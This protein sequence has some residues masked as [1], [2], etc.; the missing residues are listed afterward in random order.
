MSFILWMLVLGSILLILALA[1]AYLRLLPV[2]TSAFYLL[3]GLAIGPL[4]LGLWDDELGGVSQWLERLVEVTVLISLFIGGLRLRLP[5]RAPEWRA[6]CLL[7][8]PVLVGTILGLALFAHY[9]LGLDWGLALLLAAILSPTDPVLASLIQVSHAGDTDP[10]RFALS[11]EAG[12]NDGIAFPFVLAG[13][14]LMAYQGPAEVPLREGLE[15][16][17]RYVLWAIPAGLALGFLLGRGVGQLVIHLRARHTDT[18]VS[19]ND[20]LAL[21]LI[22]MSYVGA[23][24][25]GGWGFLS[26]FAAGLGLRQA[27][28]ATS[29]HEQ[30]PAEDTASGGERREAS[31]SQA[32]I[33]FGADEGQHRQVAAGALMVDI[34]AFGNLLERTLEVLLVT[35][36]G[37]LLYA[38]WDWRALTLALGLFVLV[39]PVMVMALLGGRLLAPSQRMLVGWFGIR[40]IGS[41]YYLCH[42]LNLGLDGKAAALAS[43][44]VISVVALSILLH[45][46]TIQPLLERYQR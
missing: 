26:T 35:I 7:A 37:A 46:L 28:V 16:F 27:E 8:G 43:D 10:M 29:G 45:G 19:P 3:F 38:H 32:I 9:A 1:S 13:L 6:A 17:M 41:L 11:G 34:L 22:A 44:L 12:L 39:R 18:T 5:F 40:G 21:A 20:F 36:L 2:S 30:A 14:L 4:G 23:E 42:A 31:H 15:W 25:I 33:D 24:S